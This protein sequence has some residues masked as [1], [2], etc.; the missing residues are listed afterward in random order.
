MHVKGDDIPPTKHVGFYQNITPKP[1]QS[2]GDPDPSPESEDEDPNPESIKVKIIPYNMGE[3]GAK[4]VFV[5]PTDTIEKLQ[6]KAG[7]R[8]LAHPTN[9]QI[10]MS[11]DKLVSDYNIKD[12]DKIW[13]KTSYIPPI[14]DIQ[15]ATMA[16]I[17]Y[18]MNVNG[19]DTINKIN[20]RI[21]EHQQVSPNETV[22]LFFGVKRL[23]DGTMTIDRLNIPV[24]GVVSVVRRP[25]IGRHQDLMRRRRRAVDF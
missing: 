6:G 11:H 14:F 4:E 12:G 19:S 23:L 16:G 25:T 1:S 21:L 24:D 20:R 13:G 8:I 15:I 5:N 17:Q 9:Q 18:P 3:E 2:S 22:D 10:Q 7:Y